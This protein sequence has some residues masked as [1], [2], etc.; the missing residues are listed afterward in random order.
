MLLLAASLLA[1]DSSAILCSRLFIFESIALIVW[2]QSV[3]N[4]YSVFPHTGSKLH[5]GSYLCPTTILQMIDVGL[6]NL[7]ILLKPSHI[8]AGHFLP[9]SVHWWCCTSPAPPPHIC[10]DWTPASP[11]QPCPPSSAPPAPVQCQPAHRT[12]T[13]MSLNSVKTT[14]A[15][16]KGLHAGLYKCLVFSMAAESVQ[17][18]WTEPL[19]CPRT[20]SPFVS[21]DS[22]VAGLWIELLADSPPT[23]A[24]KYSWSGAMLTQGKTAWKIIYGIKH[25]FCTW[26]IS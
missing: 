23:P 18:I 6:N 9:P 16:H 2:T 26:G 12:T 25:L 22:P 20:A 11:Y 17:I 1:S 21:D 8:Q 7:K 24:Q 13:R 3:L 5:Q 15:Q 19:F 14:W 10:T 4:I